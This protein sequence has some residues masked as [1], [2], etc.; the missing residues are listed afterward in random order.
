MSAG[1]GSLAASQGMRAATAQLAEEAALLSHPETTEHVADHELTSKQKRAW[2]GIACPGLTQ[3][4]RIAAVKALEHYSGMGFRAIHKSNPDNNPKVAR[5][6]E[7]ID[8][9]LGGKNAPIYK[10]AIYRGVDYSGSEAELRKI[11]KS[12]Q[13]TETGITSFSSD[14]GTAKSF[15][16]AN[17]NWSEGISVILRVPAG[18]NLS[19]VP[20]KHLSNISSEDEVLMPSSV[21]DRGWTIKNSKWT[22]NEHG[23]KVVYLDVEENLRRKK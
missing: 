2:V 14:A 7:L 13:W 17:T 9:V 20:F 23:R 8:R 21:K 19:G 15:A 5:E 1:G 18:K 6:I 22:T 10:G 3:E 12:G 11:I 16:H 4:E